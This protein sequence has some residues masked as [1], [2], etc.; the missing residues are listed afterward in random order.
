MTALPPGSTIGML[1]AGQLGRMTALAAARLGYRL[2]VF[3]PEGRDSS[4]GQVCAAVTSADWHDQ[5]A[6]ARFAAAVDVVTLEWENVPTDTV[7]FLAERVPVHPGAGVLA[8]AQDRLREKSFAN[9]QG[10]R[11]APFRPVRSAADLRAAVAD[12]GTPAILKS[13]RL[14]YDGKGQVRIQPD[15]DLERAWADLCGSSPAG[16]EGILEGFVTFACEVSVIVARRAD[17]AMV[18]YPPVENR[19]KAGILDVTLAPATLDAAVAAEA[20]RVAERLTQALD[21]VGLLAVEMFVTPDGAVLVN[22]MAPRPHNS[23]HWSLDFCETSQF[24]QLVRAVCGLPLGPTGI[25]E[26]CAMTNLIGSDVEA[27]P[28]LMAE[29]GAR[30]HL[31]GKGEGRP[32]RKMGHVTRPLTI[33]G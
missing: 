17:G 13:T 3:S 24:E 4:C 7:A 1:G 25:T 32:G 22:E 18:S 20:R 6:L 30:L 29:P 5:T 19:H 21:V 14:G 27:W 15:T 33:P 10:L 28:A 31:Y 23:G 11:T 9:A 26:P 12:L 8:V 2:H 16:V